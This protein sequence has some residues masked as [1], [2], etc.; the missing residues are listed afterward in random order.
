MTFDGK[1]GERRG[2]DH[3]TTDL[4]IM[5]LAQEQSI[6]PCT[7][8]IVRTN[9]D[10]TTSSSSVKVVLHLQPVARN[11]SREIRSEAAVPTSSRRVD[12]QQSNRRQGGR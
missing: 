12:R 4:S 3:G 10:G 11:E 5:Y 7:D 8:V 9:A 1:R 6:E 2:R